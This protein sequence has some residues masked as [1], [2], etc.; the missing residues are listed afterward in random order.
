MMGLLEMYLMY[1]QAGPA[2]GPRTWATKE[3]LA[4]GFAFLW[5]KLSLEK[6]IRGSWLFLLFSKTYIPG[7]SFVCAHLTA[8]QPKLQHRIANFH[9]IV[10]S[11]LFPP[12]PSSEDRS[13]STLYSTSHLFFL[14]D[15]NFRVDLPDNH[16]MFN[17]PSAHVTEALRESHTRQT[18]KEFDQLLVERRKR[19][20][21]IGFREGEFWQFKCSYKYRLNA[22]DH[23]EWA[24]PSFCFMN[25]PL[26]TDQLTYFL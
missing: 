20:V 23:Y 14:G 11:L 26:W 17:N 2:V 12:L 9:H 13:P 16:E 3:R 15:L 25:K 4:F 7:Y 24:A 21:F 18:L 8:H 6:H 19:S 10:G 22:V 1:R 5:T